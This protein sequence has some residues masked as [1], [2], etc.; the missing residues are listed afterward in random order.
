MAGNVVLLA[1]APRAMERVHQAAADKC[2]RIDHARRPH[3]QLAI[4]ARI[5]YTNELSREPEQDLVRVGELLLVIDLLDEEDTENVGCRP[6]HV[7]HGGDDGML[8]DVKRTRVQGP[9]IAEGP[10]MGGWKSPRQQLPEWQDADLDD[11][12][13]Q[14]ERGR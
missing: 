6:A 7:G 8:L 3:E 4:Q 2:A 12:R 9:F 11:E 5:G 10:E 13:V 1:L 14:S